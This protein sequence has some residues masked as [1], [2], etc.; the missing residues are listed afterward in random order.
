MSERTKKM[1]L[2]LLFLIFCVGIAFALYFVFFQTGTKEQELTEEEYLSVFESASLPTSLEGNQTSSSLTE[3]TLPKADEVAKGGVTKTQTLTLS[4]V[5]ASKLQGNAINY[6]DKNDGKFYSIDEQGNV[7]NLSQVTFPQAKGVYW[8]AQADK[9]VIEFP[10]GS[11]VVYDFVTN[12]QITLPK[13]WED[14]HFSPSAS[15]E[16]IAKSIGENPGNRALI[17]SNADGSNVQ[18]VQALGE[19]ADKVLI[20]PS[21]HDQVI[22]FSDTASESTGF[23][24][25]FLIPL[26]KNKENFKGLIVDGFGFA[27][28]WSPRGDLLLYSASDIENDD[29]QLWTVS[30][31]VDRLG[32][33]RQRLGVK[34]WVDKCVFSAQTEV[35]CAVPEYLPPHAGLQRSLAK[36]IPDNIYKIDLQSGRSTLIG[37]T[38]VRASL[39]NL[40]ISSDGKILYFI[41][42][43]TGLLQSIH[44]Q[45]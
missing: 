14:F 2:L 29:P 18:A 9:A 28:I 24:T 11:N 31:S 6:Y 3:E 22:A 38:D 5:G 20:S 12:T 1:F 32:D 35:Y 13:H 4:P 17:V 41:N 7:K 8:N 21:P 44:L 16:I 40:H 39:I 26:G 33:N 30:G 37:S 43:E 25:N 15:G 23:G 42:E 36:G 45:L 10:D 27:A 34:T 19:N